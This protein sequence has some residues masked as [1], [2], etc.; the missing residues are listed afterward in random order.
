MIYIIITS[1]MILTIVPPKIPLFE[2]SATQTYGI[3]KQLKE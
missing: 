2:D 3:Y 1:S